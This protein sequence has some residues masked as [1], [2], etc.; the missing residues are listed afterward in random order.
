MI[1]VSQKKKQKQMVYACLEILGSKFGPL[2][3][4]TSLCND[5][6]DWETW[7]IWLRGP[8]IDRSRYQTS[9][10]RSHC[11]PSCSARFGWKVGGTTGPV[12]ISIYI[13]V[14]LGIAMIDIT[15]INRDQEREN[16][17][18]RHAKPLYRRRAVMKNVLDENNGDCGR[19][20]SNYWDWCARR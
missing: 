9:R 8:G 6:T 14:T 4:W 18:G 3:L 1:C 16:R 10:S 20:S 19:V 12:Q 13:V 2:C 17:G 7:A 15:R 5:G 11:T